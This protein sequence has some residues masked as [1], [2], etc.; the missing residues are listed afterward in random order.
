MIKILGRCL[1]FS[2]PA[3]VLHFGLLGAAFCDTIISTIPTSPTCCGESIGNPPNT[4]LQEAI[5]FVPDGS[6]VLDS[7]TFDLVA[8]FGD[9]LLVAQIYSEQGGLPGTLLD[10]L[11]ATAPAPAAGGLFTITATS[12]F[13]LQSGV[14]YWL[15]GTDTD[16]NS[17]A[18]WWYSDQVGWRAAI[19]LPGHTAPGFPTWG[20]ANGGG[21]AGPGTNQSEVLAFEI[22]GTVV[23]EPPM[24]SLIGLMG[25]ALV[26]RRA[27]NRQRW[28]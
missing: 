17:G 18:Y 24:V 9:G 16:P 12:P 14:A 27:K 10:S 7:V 21:P 2:L 28:A 5:R 19:D 15:T 1:Y 6:Y 8:S 20:N 22:D 25:V 13:V 23:P 11:T 3:I 26:A 4:S